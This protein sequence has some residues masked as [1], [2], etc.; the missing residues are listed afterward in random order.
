MSHFTLIFSWHKEQRLSQQ[1][2][3]LAYYLAMTGEQL[4]ADVQIVI[5]NKSP[6]PLTDPLTGPP[7]CKQ[8]LTISVIN[9]RGNRPQFTTMTIHLSWQHLRRSTKPL[10]AHQN[11]NRSRYPTM[12]LS[13]MVYHLWAST[14]YRQ[15]TY[16]IWSLYLHSL[17]RYKRW[18]KMSK[19]G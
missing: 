14:C 15:P 6:L 17:W 16:Q 13:G 3:L 7:C 11:L 1:C 19:M 5:N 2:S 10:N 18:Y 8:M 4:W 9:W 12:P